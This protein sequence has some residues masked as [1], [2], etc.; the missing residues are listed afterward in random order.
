MARI[1]FLEIHACVFLSRVVFIFRFGG[2]VPLFW[3]YFFSNDACIVVACVICSAN[4]ACVFFSRGAFILIV[5][6]FVFFLVRRV[7]VLVV[8]CFVLKS[9][10]CFCC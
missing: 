5:C 10:V 2:H 1:A 9:D 8:D 7:F 3:E 4:H 6:A